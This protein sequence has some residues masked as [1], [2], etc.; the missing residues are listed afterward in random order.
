MGAIVLF[1]LSSVYTVHSNST[2]IS[3]ELSEYILRL[4]LNHKE[5]MFLKLKERMK[6]GLAG[7]NR[8]WSYYLLVK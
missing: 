8:Y 2:K 3:K 5:L 7:N 4:S 1:F 6:E